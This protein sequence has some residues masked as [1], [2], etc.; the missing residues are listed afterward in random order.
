MVIT[1]TTGNLYGQKTRKT[2]GDGRSLRGMKYT[3]MGKY[4][5]IAIGYVLCQ[6]TIVR[7]YNKYLLKHLQ[8]I[9][10]CPRVC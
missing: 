6:I 2:K 7:C 10:D 3:T 5:K 1:S 4:I 8:D 9:Q